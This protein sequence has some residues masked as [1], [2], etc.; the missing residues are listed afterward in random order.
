MLTK[1]D[2]LSLNFCAYFCRHPRMHI[3]T[4]LVDAHLYCLKKAVVDFLADNKW[5]CLLFVPLNVAEK[6]PIR[7]RLYP[8]S[9][10]ITRVIGSERTRPHPLLYLQRALSAVTWCVRVWKVPLAGVFRRGVNLFYYVPLR[11]A[12]RPL[13]SEPKSCH[14]KQCHPGTTRGTFL[15]FCS[16]CHS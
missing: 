16:V 1:E 7:S 14:R 2:V 4:G 13:A 9:V 5:V 8:W 12:V 10:K 6:L 15:S 11:Q 3:R